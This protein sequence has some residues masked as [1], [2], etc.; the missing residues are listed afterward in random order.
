MILTL[1]NNLRGGISSVM[2]D[3]YIKSDESKKILNIYAINIYGW[4]MSE[5]LLYYE[6]EMWLGHPDL[7]NNEL[8]E[9]LNTSDDSVIGYFVEVDL[10]SPNIIQETKNFPFCPE[11]KSIHKDK[12]I[13]YMKKIKPKIYTKTKN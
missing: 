8:E 13:D 1:E 7:Y 3:R 10:K 9:I 4:A 11:I 5:S 12:Y 6:I 2:G